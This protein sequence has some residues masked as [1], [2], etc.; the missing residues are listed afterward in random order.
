MKGYPSHE[1]SDIKNTQDYPDEAIDR[2][3]PYN[4]SF[5][6]FLFVIYK[7]VDK[8]ERIQRLLLET[9]LERKK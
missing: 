4:R 6:I 2:E 7:P 1:N 5:S 9:P 3:M 8:S